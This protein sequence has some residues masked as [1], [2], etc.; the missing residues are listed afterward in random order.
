MFENGIIKLQKS[1][2]DAEQAD[3]N[4]SG[5]VNL[6]TEEIDMKVSVKLKKASG[7]SMSVPLAMKIKGTFTAP[8]AKVDMKSVMD[9]PVVKDNL[10]KLLDGLLKK[11]K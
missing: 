3:V 1:T 7:I 4:A 6:V 8:E 9:Q 11:K 2:L 10:K 5:S